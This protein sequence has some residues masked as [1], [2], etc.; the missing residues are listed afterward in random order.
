VIWSNR[1]TI[2]FWK[3][4]PDALMR[5]GSIEGLARGVK[6]TIQLL[7]LKDEQV[8][9]TLSSDTSQKA[10]TDRIGAFRMGR[11]GE[12]RDAEGIGHARE[13]GSKLVIT[14]TN[15]MV[16]RLSIRSRLSQRYGRSRRR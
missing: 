10:F 2:L 16:R 1:L 5:P 9:E 4:L 3:L 12:H 14:I 7:L 8:I 6:D 15:E 11:R 13:T